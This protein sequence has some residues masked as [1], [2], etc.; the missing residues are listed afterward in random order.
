MLARHVDPARHTHL[1]VSHA[2]RLAA[3]ATEKGRE[4]KSMHYSKFADLDE[5]GCEILMPLL[6]AWGIDTVVVVGSWSEVCI[7]ATVVEAVDRYGL[8]CVVVEDAVA[9][10]CAAHWTSM[11]TMKQ[12]YA[13]MQ[14]TADFCEW[15]EKT[16]NLTPC[17]AE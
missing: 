5:H 16:E 1:P 15:M 17:G 11:F 4:I 10:G 13:L 6:R 7:L 14:T 8:D 9:T 3:L 12:A 2:A